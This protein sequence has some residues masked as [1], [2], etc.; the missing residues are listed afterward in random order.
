[1]AGPGIRYWEFAKA[2]SK[3]HEV[4]LLVPNECDATSQEFTI[5]KN[6]GGFY[7]LLKQVDVLVTM[8]VPH[9]LALAAKM[10]GVKIILDAY[11]PLPLEFLE[12]YKE[13][14]PFIRQRVQ[15]TIAN[16]FNTSVRMADA[17]ICANENQRDLWT[18]LLLSL[19]KIHPS[20]YDVDPTLKNIIDIVP[21]GLP[22]T[23]PVKQGKGPR[24]L[25]HLK[26]SD[27][28][29]LWGGGI[30]DWF[31]P[32]TLIQAIS[33]IAQKRT[34]IHLVFMGIKITGDSSPSMMSMPEKAYNLAKDLDLLNKHV[35]FN[36]G[37]VPYEERASFFLEAD[38]GI[39]TH[40]EHLETRYAFRTRIL[41]Y[42]WAG[43]PIISTEGDCFS[44]LIK[45]KEL[46][47]IVP[48]RNV[49]A[50][51]EAIVTLIDHSQLSAKIK[52]NIETVRQD[53][54]W[55]HVIKPIENII[56]NFKGRR[57]TLQG[58]ADV[59]GSICRTRGSIFYFKSLLNRIL[60]RF[61]LLGQHE[62]RNN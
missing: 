36:P 52:K 10:H 13:F 46:G 57:S 30:W 7:K 44:R 45:E 40:F 59:L 5:R 39:S 22:A 18:G 37:W 8:E 34:D 27:K 48:Y 6:T 4:I 12:V 11:D 15:N 38:I 23:P 31:D 20:L 16:S 17:V 29:V 28:I 51:A 2:L 21:F 54:Y 19:K 35:F 32:L 14:D 26:Q 55:D 25:F 61:G 49:E 33:L 62:R 60:R 56:S 58:I 47:L 9:S 3:N 43:L 41:D 24:E 1:M 53:F 50:L 42:L